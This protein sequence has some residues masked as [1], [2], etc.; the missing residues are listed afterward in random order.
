MPQ[1]EGITQLLQRA[2]NGE[3]AAANQLMPVIYEQLHALARRQLYGEQQ[4]PTLSATALVNEAYLLLFGD[5]ELTWL[6]RGHFFAYAAKAMRNIL[7]DHARQRLTEKRGG[8]VARVDIAEVEIGADDES[9]DL[10]AMDQ[11]LTQMAQVH[12]R[13]VQ[14]VELRFFAGLSV[15]EAAQSLAIDAR[16]VKRD[17]QKARAYIHRAL[18]RPGSK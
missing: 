1:I 11:V 8:Q 14:V 17:W 15:E 10:L 3:S 4:A 9:I 16:S 6:D 12:P 5:A 7:I 2:A 18:E 13:L